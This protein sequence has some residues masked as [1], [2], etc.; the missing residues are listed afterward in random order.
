MMKKSAGVGVARLSSPQSPSSSV[1]AN[2]RT[3][4]ADS[5]AGVLQCGL[6][7]GLEVMS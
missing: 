2:I 3:G 7:Q 4:F 5:Q 1:V 6:T